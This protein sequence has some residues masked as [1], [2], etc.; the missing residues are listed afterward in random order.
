MGYWNGSLTG[1]DFAFD[2]VSLTIDLIADRMF[3]KADL[4]ITKEHAEQ[5]ILA[6]LSCI[7]ILCEAHP[8]NRQVSFTKKKYVT[9][10]EK[11]NQWYTLVEK[12]IPKKHRED[13]K[14]SADEE[15]ALWEE[16]IFKTKES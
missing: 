2:E 7:R 6:S 9:A 8:K 13:L 15:F 5:S 14:K 11:F 12:K 10:K 16:R 4:V 3:E 1:S